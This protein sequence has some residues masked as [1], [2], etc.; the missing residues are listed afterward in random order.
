MTQATGQMEVRWRRFPDAA[1]VAEAVAERILSTARQAI[2]AR[3]KFTLV[4]AGG[5][6]PKA[7]YS[8][9]RQATAEWGRWFIYFGDE[10]CL[11]A[12]HPER[13]S[14]M[15]ADCWLDHVAIPVAN[16]FPIAAERGSQAAAE[17]YLSQV[18]PALPFDLLL[19]GMGEDG[20]TASLFPGHPLDINALVVPVQDAPKPPPERVSLG[21]GALNQSRET[22]ILVTGAGKREAVS[23][24][25]SGEALPVAQVHGLN[26]AEVFIDSAADSA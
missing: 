12:D 9:L 4:L 6:T 17:A 16:I 24:W 26:G 13:N 8:L 7:A 10:R 2:S 1:A 20:H 18:E 21:L 14:R 3:G 11:P 23:Q 19:L 22:L 15:A 5:T 25:R